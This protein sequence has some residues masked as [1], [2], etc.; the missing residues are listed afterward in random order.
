[1]VEAMESAFKGGVAVA[2]GVDIVNLESN[3]CVVEAK[4]HGRGTCRHVISV[5]FQEMREETIAEAARDVY[6]ETGSSCSEHTVVR[7]RRAN[8]RQSGRC[9]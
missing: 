3:R 6:A 9:L 7:C 2:L 1:M 5:G 8:A 4:W